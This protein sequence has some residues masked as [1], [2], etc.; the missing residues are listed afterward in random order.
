MC[1]VIPPLPQYT[2][3]AWCSVKKA[4]R[5][6]YL[7][8]S[9]IN[10]DYSR[11]W[12]IGVHFPAGTMMGFFSL[13]PHSGRLWDLSDLLSNWYRGA[14]IPGVKWPVRRTDYSPP[15]SA[16]VKNPWNCTSVPPIRLHGVVLS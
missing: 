1:G 4:Q 11:G 10:V 6:L 3:M 12:T 5:Q 14:F 2:S 7:L 15:S 16:E 9:D 13:P 8:R